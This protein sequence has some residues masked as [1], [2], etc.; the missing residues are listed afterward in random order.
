MDCPYCGSA[1][2]VIDSRPDTDRVVRR[3]KCLECER[4]FFT[5]ESELL[6]SQEDFN[7]LTR[8]VYRQ[9]CIK[10]LKKELRK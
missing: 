5:T 9:S 7:R 2:R 1:T 4:L 6:T 3:R 8:G 10:R